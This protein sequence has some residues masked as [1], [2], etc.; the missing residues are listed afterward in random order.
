MSEPWASAFVRAR[1]CVLFPPLAPAQGT[2]PKKVRSPFASGGSEFKDQYLGRV[3]ENATERPSIVSSDRGCHE[4]PYCRPSK[5]LIRKSA[6][7]ARLGR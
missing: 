7:P 2:D 3:A 4:A 6:I 5:V 1:P